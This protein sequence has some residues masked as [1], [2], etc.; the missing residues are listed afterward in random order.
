MF[1]AVR[2]SQALVLVIMNVNDF[3]LNTTG[4][5]PHPVSAASTSSGSNDTK[6]SS[7]LHKRKP[8]C[9]RCTLHGIKTLVKGHGRFCRYRNC[10]CETCYVVAGGG[11][12][13]KN[14]LRMLRQMERER[15]AMQG[16]KKKLRKTDMDT[17]SETEGDK[18]HE[19]A[20][21]F[22]SGT[23]S[24]AVADSYAFPSLY[25]CYTS[26]NPSTSHAP[27]AV[28]II[29][30]PQLQRQLTRRYHPY[31][32][33]D[34]SLNVAETIVEKRR[35]SLS[36]S[37]STSGK[38]QPVVHSDLQNNPFSKITPQQ[39]SYT[40]QSSS[41]TQP[42]VPTAWMT[43]HNVTIPPTQSI[44]WFTKSGPISTAVT[45]VT[46]ISSSGSTSG[47]TLPIDPGTYPN[48]ASSIIQQS[49][50]YPQLP[51]AC[52]Q[53]STNC[54]LQPQAFTPKADLL[55]MRREGGFVSSSSTTNTTVP[56]VPNVCTRTAGGTI[57][58]PNTP[59]KSSL[60][61]KNRFAPYHRTDFRS[62]D[63]LSSPHTSTNR[64]PSDWTNVDRTSISTCQPV[65]RPSQSS[66]GNMPSHDAAGTSFYDVLKWQYYLNSRFLIES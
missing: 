44:P 2:A 55:S 49:Q 11:W 31:S 14:Q 4:L 61:R 43:N 12:F 13:R 37:V 10:T 26:Q 50:Q 27:N 41:E 8:T 3:E 66:C 32:E 20:T 45:P 46:Y 29:P 51:P 23:D 57:Q 47:W 58:P 56:N 18:F 52:C 19:T 60:L 21:P 40:L 39:L 7:S 42:N 24:N 34:T 48:N 17:S 35:E 53:G 5:W 54:V 16:L 59:T 30:P 64:T 38:T 36:S 63:S 22:A 25:G 9:A 65:M 1:F 28:R 62:I 15:K 33:S 6:P